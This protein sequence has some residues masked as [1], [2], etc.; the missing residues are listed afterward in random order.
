MKAVWITPS[1]MAAPLRRLL[2]VFKIAAMRLRTGGDKR[3]GR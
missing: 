3:L 2:Q 1:A